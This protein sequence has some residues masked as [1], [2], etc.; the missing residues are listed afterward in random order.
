KYQRFFKKI[1]KYFGKLVA[2]KIKY[3]QYQEIMNQ[4]GQGVGPDYLSRLNSSIRSAVQLARRD[5]L[6]INDFTEG[7]RLHAQ[8]LPK[9]PEDKYISSL[10]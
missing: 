7:V 8:K 10:S 2:S 1:D 6:N 5:L 4:I 9:N 3:S